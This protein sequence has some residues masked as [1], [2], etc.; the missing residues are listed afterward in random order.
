MALGI[1]ALK[2]QILA[3]TLMHS[4]CVRR[5]YLCVNSV[6]R[7]HEIIFGA[8]LAVASAYHIVQINLNQRGIF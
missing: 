4:M 2:I 8:N 6:S 1:K 7:L 5:A 3:A